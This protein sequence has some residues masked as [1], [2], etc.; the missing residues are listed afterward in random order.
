MNLNFRKTVLLMGACSALGIAYPSQTFAESSNVA[1]AAVQ[2]SK[3]VQGTVV[4]AMGPV[5]GASIME[6]GTSNGTVT[7]LDGNFSL[8]VKPGATLVVSYVGYQ[9]QQVAVGNNSNIKIALKED[10]KSLDEVVV[11]G[12][13][14]MK[15]KLVT[16]ATVQV[17]GDDIAKLNTT[18]VLGALQ[19]QSPGMSIVQTSGQ[20]GEQSYKVNVR[21]LGTVGNSAPLY[22]IDGFAGGDINSLNPSDIESIDVLKDAASAAIYGARAANG[23]V[24][25]TTKQGKAGKLQISYDGYVGFQYLYKHPDVLNAKEYMYA[26]DLMNWTDGSSTKDWQSLLPASEWEQIQNGWEGTD[27]VNASYHKGAV[28]TNH[29]IGLQ[30]GNDISKF[31]LGFAYTK[32]DGIFGEARQSKFERYNV[33]LNSDHVL[34]KVKNLEVIKLGENLTFSHT[35][36]SGIS[37]GNLYSNNMHDLLIGCPLLPAYNANG[38]YYSQT[39]MIADGWGLDKTAINPLIGPAKS[40]QGLKES[41]SYNLNM[42]A[43]LEIQPIKNLKLR[44]QFSYRMGTSTYRS[45]NEKY[46]N[47]LNVVSTEQVNQNMSTWS[48]WSWENTL[49]YKLTAGLHTADFVI[50]NSLEKNSYGMSMSA[51][52]ANTLFPEDWS[53]A[54]LSNTKPAFVND[55]IGN[56]SFS[57]YPEGD[58]SLASFFGRASYNYNETYLAQFTLRADGSSNFKRGHRWGYFPSASIGW[59][60]TNEKF[61]ENTKSW[62]DFLKIRASWGQNGNCNI[63]NFQYLTSF[64]FDESNGYFFGDPSSSEPAE[65]TGAYADVLKNEDLKW[66]TSEQIDL[67]LDARFLN[68]RLGFTFDWYRKTTKDWLVQAPILSVYGLNA[69]YINGGDVRNTGVE[70]GLNWNDRIGKDF[71]Y[72]A[73][74][75]FAT[76][77]NEVTRI[78][79]TEGIIHGPSDVYMQGVEEIYRAKVGEPIGYFYG[80]KTAGVFQNQ[81]QIDEWKKTYT[82][83]IHGGNPVP[84]DVIYVDN[85]GDG[86][87]NLEDR[88]NI[89]DPHPDCTIGFNIHAEYKGFDFSV[90]GNGSFGQQ[91]CRSTNTGNSQVENLNQK[92]L[93]GCWKGE[94]TSNFLPALHNLSN[95]NWKTFSSIW[96]E[97]ADYVRIQNV[98]V[99]YDFCKIWKGSPFSQCR[100]Y[101]AAENLFT[102]TS[103]SGMDPEVGASGNDSYSW[104]Q[105][106]DLGFY[107]VPRTYMIGVNIKF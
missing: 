85:N 104:G 61:M 56:G 50:G 51:R 54:Y 103:Y 79:N 64:K 97:D 59:V 22:V 72:G 16:G 96:L 57:G 88:T 34:Y 78:A 94:G 63:S 106:I 43:Y 26:Y 77:K 62:M 20:P 68:S 80:M 31:S 49:S 81:A 39:D 99:G 17:K 5:I 73:A 92:L 70:L 9:S 90:T 6:K 98:T 3:K 36:N 24:L 32:Q 69:P 47:G 83:E 67:G 46:T 8:N 84:G 28:K 87:V 11:V 65:T 86:K 40:S 29:S 19:S 82:D 7:D 1:A 52:G 38:D 93:Y 23:V 27:W 35:G 75:N 55:I 30:G 45:Y 15:K 13:G 4:D 58:S 41:K 91:V 101:F 12:Y 10:S 60:V 66:E 71:T 21:G 48:N 37:T 44:S 14:T 100:L 53:H 89:G 105:G 18:N 76:N 102:F 107:P 42:N 2:Q 25:V 74:F 95:V 33:R